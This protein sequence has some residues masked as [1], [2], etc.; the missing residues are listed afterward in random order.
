[1][2]IRKKKLLGP[3]PPNHDTPKIFLSQYHS[4][5]AQKFRF[6]TFFGTCHEKFVIFGI[7]WDRPRCRDIQFG[8]HCLRTYYSLTPTIEKL[9]R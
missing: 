3:P 4:K 1:M 5:I 8:I 9:P 7:F 6:V 2:S